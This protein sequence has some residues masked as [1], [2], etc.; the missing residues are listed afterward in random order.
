METSTKLFYRT[1]SNL[2]NNK[3]CREKKELKY[4]WLTFGNIYRQSFGNICGQSFGNEFY[5]F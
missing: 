3:I 1:L 2:V 4:A 5:F